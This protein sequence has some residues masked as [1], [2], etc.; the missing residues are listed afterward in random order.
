MDGSW[1]DGKPECWEGNE[2]IE[3][4]VSRTQPFMGLPAPLHSTGLQ[5]RVV[6]GS[7]LELRFAWHPGLLARLSCC[8]KG[9]LGLWIVTSSSPQIPSA[10]APRHSLRSVSLQLASALRAL[11]SSSLDQHRHPEKPGAGDCPLQLSELIL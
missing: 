2:I 11:L 6:L 7:V 1:E 10:W 4:A 8:F 3:E 9:H 5:A